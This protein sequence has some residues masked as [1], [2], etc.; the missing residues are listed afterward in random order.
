MKLDHEDSE[1]VD[2]DPRRAEAVP[3]L[4]LDGS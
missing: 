1:F 2:D 4:L 3:V